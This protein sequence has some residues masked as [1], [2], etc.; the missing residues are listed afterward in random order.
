MGLDFIFLKEKG[1]RELLFYEVLLSVTCGRLIEDFLKANDLTET[2]Y[3]NERY[4]KL[5]I[6]VLT[7]VQEGLN[8]RAIIAKFM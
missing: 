4:P 3:V 5:L 1:L 7:G 2:E 8:P 6:S